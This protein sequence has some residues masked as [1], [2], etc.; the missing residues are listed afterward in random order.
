MEENDLILM[1]NYDCRRV[2]YFNYF[3]IVE[4]KVFIILTIVDMTLFMNRIGN[5]Y[6][7]WDFTY[8]DYNLSER[9]YQIVLTWIPI[10]I[11][12]GKR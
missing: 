8:A 3:G 5:T 11:I 7:Q 2:L 10:K 1:Q 4:S 9:Y 12:K 6:K